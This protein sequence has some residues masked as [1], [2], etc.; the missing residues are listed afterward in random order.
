MKRRHCYKRGNDTTLIFRKCGDTS[1]LALLLRERPPMSLLR[2]RSLMFGKSL[3]LV[4][5]ALDELIS[6]IEPFDHLQRLTL[7]HI[8]LSLER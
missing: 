7:L 3:A 8:A 5:G 6:K 2:E 1:C 4:S